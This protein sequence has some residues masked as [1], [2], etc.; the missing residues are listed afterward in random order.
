MKHTSKAT[1]S[2]AATSSTVL[3]AALAYAALDW[4]VL[5]LHNVLADGACSCGGRPCKGKP[6]KHPRTAHGL[7]D[8]S[9]DPQTIR[10][11]WTTW[12]AANVGVCTGPESGLWVL[13]PDG[14]AGALALDRL[15]GQHGL[16]PASPRA[17]SGSGGQHWLFRWPADG[18]PI[19]NRANHQGAPIDVRG[20]GGYI[21]AAPS[22]N[23]SGAYRWFPDYA[24][25][26]TE[27]ALAPS[28]L[29]AWVRDDGRPPRPAPPPSILLPREHAYPDVVRRAAAYLGR[30]PPAISGCAGHD[31]AFNVVLKVVRG[32]GLDQTTALGLLRP[33]NAR[34]KPP[35]SDAELVHKVEDAHD[36][37][38][39]PL[40]FLRDRMTIA[41]AARVIRRKIGGL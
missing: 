27:L 28:W 15:E 33:W 11:W 40:G 18:L 29:L 4:R 39:A 19:R 3:A 35:W 7:K 1:G 23:A 22:T 38:Q 26:E 8:G 32:F 34:C 12:P 20:Q 30:C 21:V 41:E 14:A 37:D 5:P 9:T 6:G 2:G 16:L 31:T 24:P 17:L 10:A 36:S 13:G 25:G